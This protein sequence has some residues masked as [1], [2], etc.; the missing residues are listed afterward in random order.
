MLIANSSD[1]TKMMQ[2]WCESVANQG[3]NLDF[4]QRPQRQSG[5]LDR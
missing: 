1:R 2:F 5:S 3:Y 4:D